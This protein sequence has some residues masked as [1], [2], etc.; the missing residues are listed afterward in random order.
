VV[1]PSPF[2]ISMYCYDKP[3]FGALPLFD[4]KAVLIL[5]LL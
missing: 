4:I 5:K 3:T 2:I 1:T